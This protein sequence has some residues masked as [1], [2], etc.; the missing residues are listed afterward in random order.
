MEQLT[1]HV[2]YRVALN[3]YCI[4]NSKFIVS[5]LIQNGLLGRWVCLRY[6]DFLGVPLSYI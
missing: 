1:Y 6:V 2:L 3:S 4:S 5:V